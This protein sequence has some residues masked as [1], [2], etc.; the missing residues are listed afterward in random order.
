MWFEINNHTLFETFLVQSF[1]SKT[2]FTSIRGEVFRM[3]MRMRK[4][5][6]N[7]NLT[8][9][10]FPQRYIYSEWLKEKRIYIHDNQ[11]TVIIKVYNSHPY[12][13]TEISQRKQCY[14]LGK[15]LNCLLRKSSI[16]GVLITFLFLLPDT[17]EVFR[18]RVIQG[19][20]KGRVA[21]RSSKGVS[22]EF[23]D[24]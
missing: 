2:I 6:V 4:Y 17:N 14:I 1:S 13:T 20:S 23:E 24:V 18:V 11:L 15:V 22:R 5:E 9:L 16:V 10:Y 8:I 7:K 19:S 12:L 3:M 21:K